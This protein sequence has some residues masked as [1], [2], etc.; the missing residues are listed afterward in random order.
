MKHQ[1]SKNKSQIPARQQAGYPIFQ[2]PM[3]KTLIS[4][5]VFGNCILEFPASPAARQAGVG[6]G[7]FN[8]WCFFYH[9]SNTSYVCSLYSGFMDRIKD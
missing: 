2:I 5:D 4:L 1:I 8:I 3:I 7:I 6:A 9:N